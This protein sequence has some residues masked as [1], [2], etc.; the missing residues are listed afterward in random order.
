MSEG[1]DAAGRQ[2]QRCKAVFPGGEQ[3]QEKLPGQGHLRPV[4]A[5]RSPAASIQSLM[6]VCSP[7]AGLS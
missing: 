3:H 1:E 7:S 6:F 4:R 5:T 2:A